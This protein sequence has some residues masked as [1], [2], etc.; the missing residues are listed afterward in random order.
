M[1]IHIITVGKPRLSYAVAGW[2]EYATRL[3]RFHTVRTSHLHDKYAYNAT[4]ILETAGPAYIVTLE[5]TGKQ[6][7]S[8]ELA[9]FLQFR[10]LESREVCFIIGGP[11]GLPEDVREAANYKLSLS[12]LTLPHDLAMVFLLETLYRASTIN[13]NLPYHK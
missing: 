6:L 5:I 13:A 7:G 1:K 12:K 8:P 11:E 3:R 9:E 2:E 10:E 4:K